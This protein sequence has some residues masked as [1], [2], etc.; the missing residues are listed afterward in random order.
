MNTEQGNERIY[1]L[2]EKYDFSELNNIDRAF[3][4]NCMTEQE[5]NSMR[6]T[7]ADT[8]DYFSQAEEPFLSNSIFKSQENKAVQTNA[9]TKILKMPVELYKVAA[10]IAVILAIF[11]SFQHFKSSKPL[12]MLAVNDTVV[13]HKIDTVFSHFT[14]TVEVVKERVIYLSEKQINKKQ[15][16]AVSVQE[17]SYDCNRDICPNDVDRIKA[18]S[19]NCQISKDSVLADFVVTLN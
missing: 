7:I 19:I 6:K 10:S 14:D 17:L 8:A 13:V 1:E 5:Y 16:A 4:L 11:L 9:F 12:Q 15:P 3:V 18:M 2:L